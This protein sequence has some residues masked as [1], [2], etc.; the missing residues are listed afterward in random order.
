[1]LTHIAIFAGIGADSLA[2]KWAGFKSILFCEIDQDCQKVLKK[3]WPDVPIIKDVKDVTRESVIANTSS[4]RC[5]RRELE[6]QGIQL[7]NQTRPQTQSG[8]GDRGFSLNLLTA[9]TPCQPASIAGK[10]RGKDDDRWLWPQS[11]RVLCELQPD[12]AVFENPSGIGSLGE[13]GGLLEVGSEEYQGISDREAVEL[14]NIIRDIE[15]N[16][17]EVQPVAIP[18]CA[19]QAPHGRMRIFII[20][21]TRSGG[22]S[23]NA[24]RQPREVAADGFMGVEGPDKWVCANPIAYRQGEYEPM[25]T[26]RASIDGQIP[27]SGNGTQPETIADTKYQRC[28]ESGKARTLESDTTLPGSQLSGWSQNWIEVATRL[29][30]VDAG[31][32]RRLVG[33]LSRETQIKMLGNCNPPQQW[34]PV[35][36]AIADIEHKSKEE[37]K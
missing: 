24:R 14:S 7:Q 32:T 3:H 26:Q 35:L 25:R 20:C 33:S 21:H 11:I 36:K 15:K 22:L 5:H 4:I 1:M 16:G 13:L 34:Y 8:I 30:S 23:G 29:C 37:R 2:A 19:V 17:Y 28:K 12:W 9:G 18:A 10:R 31:S 6:G 27:E